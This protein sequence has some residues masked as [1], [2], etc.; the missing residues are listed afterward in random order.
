MFSKGPVV[1]ARP[2]G[3]AAV[4]RPRRPQEDAS[5]AGGGAIA[6]FAEIGRIV[7]GAGARIKGDI[8]NCSRL[9]VHGVLEADLVADFVV[10]HAGGVIRGD[11]RTENAEIN[12]TV[13]GRWQVKGRLDIR[14]TDRSKKSDEL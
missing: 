12:G 4:D 1:G 11:V 13:A 3:R 5:A 6:S 8:D 7:V 2:P 10:V 14:S 9:D